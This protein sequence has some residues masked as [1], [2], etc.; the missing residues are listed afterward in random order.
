MRRLA[1]GAG[2]ASEP[3]WQRG[4]L[5]SS[6]PTRESG[7]SALLPV[8]G[9]EE[10]RRAPGFVGARAS[11]GAR[12]RVKPFPKL[13]P[14]TV[15]ESDRDLLDCGVR[16]EVEGRM[17]AQFCV[18][19]ARPIRGGAYSPPNARY[20]GAECRRHAERSRRKRRVERDPWKRRNLPRVKTAL[21]CWARFVD[22]VGGERRLFL[23]YDRDSVQVETRRLCVVCPRP[24]CLRSGA[25]GRGEI[26]SLA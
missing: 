22:C 2:V 13:P 7:G 4:Q 9:Q 23:F 15:P 12:G 21:T 10:A 16:Y 14:Y 20:C 24:T 6:F 17:P 3:P 11:C 18:V 26:A 25:I 8:R 1:R 5:V 19:C